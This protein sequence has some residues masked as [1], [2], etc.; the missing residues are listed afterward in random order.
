MSNEYNDY[1]EPNRRKITPRFKDYTGNRAW[2]VKNQDYGEVTVHAPSMQ[3][4]IATAA[5]VWGQRWQEYD[6]YANCTADYIGT[7]VKK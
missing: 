1:M 2:K 5:S 4:A 3:A 7:E 6:F